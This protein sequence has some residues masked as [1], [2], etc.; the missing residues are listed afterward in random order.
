MQPKCVLIMGGNGAERERERE[1]EELGRKGSIDVCE[2]KQRRAA[3]VGNEIHR[4]AFVK[5]R[6]EAMA[7]KVPLGRA[8]CPSIP[9]ACK[10]AGRAETTQPC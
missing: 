9:A 3:R 10:L 1:R 5:A 4:Q 2:V 8:S 7:A 6:Q